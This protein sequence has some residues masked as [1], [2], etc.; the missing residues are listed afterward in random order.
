MKW[1][2]ICIAWLLVG[3]VAGARSG[4]AEGRLR[5]RWVFISANLL[6]DE[7]V[8]SA[9]KLLA[10][11]AR[12]GYT[13]VALAD[14]KFMLW[15]SMPARYFANVGKVRAA[16]GT[17]GLE[18]VACVMPLGYS[19]VILYREPNLAAGLPVKDAPFIVRGG[20][21]LPADEGVQV[22]NG[23]F[24]RSRRNMPTGWR[25]ADQP[26]KVSF[27]D[28][29]VKYEG[30]ASL[31]MQDI[32]VHS[33][34]HGHGRVM[35]VIQVR[36]FR[37]Y[38]VSVAVKTEDFA[39]AG[40]V[41]IA[42][43]GE[44]G[45][46]LSSADARLGRT[47]N[48]KRAHATFNSLDFSRV[49]LYLGVW[50]G[51]GGKIWWDDVR[52]EPAGL[53]NLVRRDGAP[54]RIASADGKIDCVEGR[55][56]AGAKLLGTKSFPRVATDWRAPPVMTVPPG[57]RLGDGHRV[58]ASYYHAVWLYSGQLMCCMSEPK[59]YDILD[60]QTAQVRKHLKPDGYFMLHDEIRV[61]GWDESCRRRK[62]HPAAVRR[63]GNPELTPGEILADNATR[64]V[65][66][67]RKR[68]PGKPVYVWSDM[69]DPHHNA[70]K[71]GRYYLV[72]G[73]G[74]W[75]G[76]WEGLP[77][78][79]VVVNW[80]GH[81]PGRLESL[82]H[83]AGRGHKQIL[84]GCYDGPPERIADW[85]ADA[86]KVQGV[87]GVMYTTWKGNYDDLEDFAAEVDKSVAAG[88]AGR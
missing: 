68:D 55:D 76:S 74:P 69:F 71:T 66:I 40:E 81:E 5:H 41:R 20:K 54:L 67:I 82:R 44:G 25:F 21:I 49:R 23:S 79:V 11:A 63:G 72:R 37:H 59:L 35:Q 56:F 50:G 26:G 13:G 84:A 2:V 46:T 3:A 80:H 58:L 10:R 17:H 12:A 51:K 61:Q 86:A 83:F 7:N 47:Q 57:S 18:V 65:G 52:I 39:A 60:W 6:V 77:R 88:E 32:D 36:P 1:K 53:F 28:T 64:C 31:R 42:V 30:R 22:V 70:R 14:A 15:D 16:C 27:I 34:V 45:A 4:R 43:E 24:E 29:R 78:D 19:G 33:P 48:W 38:H 87:I 62:G 8:E 75:Y 9:L 85:L 73:E